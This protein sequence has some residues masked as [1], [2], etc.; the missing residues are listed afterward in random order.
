[1]CT[2]FCIKFKP[3]K[4]SSSTRSYSGH[5]NIFLIILFI[6]FRTQLYL[7]CFTS[8]I[9]NVRH[10]LLPAR[11]KL[12]V[13]AQIWAQTTCHWVYQANMLPIKLLR[14]VSIIIDNGFQLMLNVVLF[15]TKKM[16]SLYF[17]YTPSHFHLYM[18]L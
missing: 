14:R 5:I 11:N 9:L 13:S 8:A 17:A 10:Y 2:I 15:F 4:F 16:K 18:Y 7:S 12:L 3:Q 6:I 1:M